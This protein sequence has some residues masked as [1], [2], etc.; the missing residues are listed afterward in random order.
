MSLTYVEQCALEVE[1]YEKHGNYQTRIKTGSL[2]VRYI[3]GD[4]L[5]HQAHPQAPE[6][7]NQQLAEFVAQRRTGIKG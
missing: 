4:W 6:R 7:I 5:W 3:E 1:W 2:G